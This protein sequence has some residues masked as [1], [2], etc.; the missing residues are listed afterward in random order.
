ME[1]DVLLRATLTPPI[2]FFVLG[3]ITVFVR[4]DLVIP[5][6]VS[7]AC[8]IFLLISIGLEGGAEGIE[9]IG[10]EPGL[11]GVMTVVAIFGIIVSAISAVLSAGALKSIVGFKTADAWATAG[12]YGA[13]SSATLMIAVGIAK[14]AQE[15]S[16]GELIWG[17][18]MVAANVFLDAPG[19]IAAIVLGR[20][21]LLKEGVGNKGAEVK[22]VELLHGAVFGYAIWL[23]IGGLIIG[24]ISQAFSP[25]ELGRA[26]VFFDDLFRGVLCIFLLDMGMAAARRLGELKEYGRKLALAVLAA[27]GLPQIWAITAALGMY[28][29]NLMFPGLLGWGDAFVF[30]AM[31]GSASYISAPPAMRAAIPEANPSVYL[32]MSLALTFPFNVIISIPLWQILCMALWGAL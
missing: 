17:D 30:T 24:A 11:L 2:L 14:A 13:V 31:A 12:L 7:A 16:P 15:A 29:I 26:M 22:K 6:A 8:A 20:L 9:A 28:G 4:S 19:V 32:P 21:A 3:M 1:L 25:R 23:M 10:I 5:P 18:W 27:F